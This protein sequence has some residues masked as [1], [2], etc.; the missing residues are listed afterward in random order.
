VLSATRQGNN[1]GEVAQSLGVVWPACCTHDMESWATVWSNQPSARQSREEGMMVEGSRQQRHQG[2]PHG[3]SMAEP[4]RHAVCCCAA[5]A[6]L[7]TPR[8]LGIFVSGR[9]A[10]I[11]HPKEIT[12]RFCGFLVSAC[13]CSGYTCKTKTAVL[14]LSGEQQAHAT[15][16][17]GEFSTNSLSIGSVKQSSPY[18]KL[19]CLRAAA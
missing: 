11:G 5:A 6:V 7:S 15:L 10:C 18:S 9:L 13:I 19:A 14:R 16:R 1:K 8:R 3:H 2:H 17:T 12:S 4:G